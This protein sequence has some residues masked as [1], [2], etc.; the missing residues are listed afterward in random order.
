MLAL[1]VDGDVHDVPDGVVARAD[2]VADES[3]VV[4]RGEA[5]AGGLG[6]LEHEHGERPWRGKARRSIAMT[7]GRSL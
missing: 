4:E 6:E 2:Q 1:D 5:D 7:R 3:P